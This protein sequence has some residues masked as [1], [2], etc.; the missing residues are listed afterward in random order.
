MKR[1]NLT[2]LLRPVSVKKNLH[3]LREKNLQNLWEPIIQ[4]NFLG[5]I[6]N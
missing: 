5:I 3:N 1:E 6:I 2:E 4:A